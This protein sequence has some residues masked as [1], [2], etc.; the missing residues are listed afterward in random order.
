MNIVN[1][2]GELKVPFGK[3]NNNNV[4]AYSC[5]TKIIINESLVYS[6]YYLHLLVFLHFLIYVHIYM[7]K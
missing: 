3:L 1:A 2:F 7:I 4:N 6:N 5:L